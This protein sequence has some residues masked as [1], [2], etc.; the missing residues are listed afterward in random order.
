MLYEWDANFIAKWMVSETVE[1]V[2]IVII[3]ALLFFDHLTVYSAVARHLIPV[4]VI[5]V[6]LATKQEDTVV[7][8]SQELFFSSDP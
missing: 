2:I 4:K 8:V 1:Y 6:M 3:S 7:D 5:V